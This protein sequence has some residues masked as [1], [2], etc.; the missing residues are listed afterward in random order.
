MNDQELAE[1]IRRARLRTPLLADQKIPI[2]VEV[3]GRA[4]RIDCMSIM[5]PAQA[6]QLFDVVG[7]HI[8]LYTEVL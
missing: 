4:Y 2:I 5:P 1:E 7:H 8:I 6:K 3:D